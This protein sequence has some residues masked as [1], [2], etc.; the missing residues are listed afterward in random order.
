MDWDLFGC[1]W[2]ESLVIFSVRG[3]YERGYNLTSSES[4]SLNI[5]IFF[6]LEMVFHIL[7]R[8]IRNVLAEDLVLNKNSRQNI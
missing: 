6:Y 5:I 1:L 3:E 7:C 4:P 2:A 8:V